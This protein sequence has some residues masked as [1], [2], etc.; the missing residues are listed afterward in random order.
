LSHAMRFGMSRSHR[1]MMPETVRH[2]SVV[3]IVCGPVVGRFALFSWLVAQP[4]CAVSL[5]SSATQVRHTLGS[6]LIECIALAL[7][8][9]HRCRIGV[10]GA[11]IQLLTVLA[12]LVGIEQAEVLIEA[13][14]DRRRGSPSATGREHE[15]AERETRSGSKPRLI[16]RSHIH[17]QANTATLCLRSTPNAGLGPLTHFARV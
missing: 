17:V 13:F 14:V 12:G 1:V 5:S 11:N 2:E 7:E 15:K 16:P 9:C 4:R 3:G 8:P 6:A 10:A